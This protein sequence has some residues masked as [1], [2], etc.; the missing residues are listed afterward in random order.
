MDHDPDQM[1]DAAA[2]RGKRPK[3]AEPRASSARYDPAC[4][5]VLVELENGCAFA[6]PARLA[7]G[8][9]RATDVEL[10]RVEILGSG[11]G[12]HWKA[13]GAD[14]SVPGMLAGLFGIKAFVDRQRAAHAGRAT[15]AAKAVSSR[16][17]GAK[18]G[19]PRKAAVEP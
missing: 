10:A 16:L 19:R 18:G 14:L 6:F 15:S 1:F 12:L 4:G 2:Q 5:R 9:E 8:L 13:L 7:K 3:R 17:N 11:Y